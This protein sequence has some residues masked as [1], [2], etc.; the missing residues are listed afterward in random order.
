[1]AGRRDYNDSHPI[2]TIMRRFT[3]WFLLLPALLLAGLAGGCETF[4]DHSLTGNLWQKDP[5][6]S[7]AESAQGGKYLYGP[8]Q[9]ATLTPLAVVGDVTV[10]GVALGAGC[11]VGALAEACQEG[12]RNGGSPGL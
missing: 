10:V 5:T 1:M 4:K 12:A 3:K 11:V 2:E 6:G 7:L 8:W 9:R